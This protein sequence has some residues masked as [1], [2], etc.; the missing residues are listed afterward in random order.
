MFEYSV[1]VDPGILTLF[2]IFILP[3]YDA[4]WSLWQYHIPMQQSCSSFSE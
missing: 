1:T 2:P 3:V 4:L